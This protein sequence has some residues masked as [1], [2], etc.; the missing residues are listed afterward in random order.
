MLKGFSDVHVVIFRGHL[1]GIWVQ[2]R[3]AH[4]SVSGL[5][6]QHFPTPN[7]RSSKEVFNTQST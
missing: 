5:T 4:L 2:Q 6:L 3:V 7:P 1:L